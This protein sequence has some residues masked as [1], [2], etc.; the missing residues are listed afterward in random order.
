MSVRRKVDIS[1]QLSNFG[2]HQVAQLILV[3]TAARG[4]TLQ[5]QSFKSTS[6]KE[7]DGITTYVMIGYTLGRSRKLFLGHLA[8]DAL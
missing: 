3:P 1:L 6:M 8:L 2:M 4:G 7:I 5:I